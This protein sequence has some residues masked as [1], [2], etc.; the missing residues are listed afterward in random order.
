MSTTQTDARARGLA[1]RNTR[2]NEI[3]AIA[4][5]ALGALLLLCLVFFNPNDTSLNSTGATATHNLVGPAGAY[6]SDALLQTFGLA[7][8]L[9]PL[10]LF[11]LAWRRFR[12][13]RLHA[14]LLRVVGL[15]TILLA[16][17][18]LLALF[19]FPLLYDHR[20]RAGGMMGTLIADTLAG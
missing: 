17:S 15:I 8:F 20:V 7:A 5:F 12:T 11:A 2:L 3:V 14:P 19:S 9:L 16:S 1:P 18:S 10:L 4:L 6:V 13:R